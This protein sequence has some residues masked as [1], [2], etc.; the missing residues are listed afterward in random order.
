MDRLGLGV[1][2]QLVDQWFPSADDRQILVQKVRPQTIWIDF[3]R[4][5]SDQIC[6]LLRSAAM[7]HRVIQRQVAS[8]DG[9]KKVLL[10]G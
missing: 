1:S 2:F 6:F 8:F 4:S 9:S 10:G 3:S 7:N 5:S